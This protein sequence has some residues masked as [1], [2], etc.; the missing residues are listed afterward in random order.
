MAPARA[1]ATDF[2]CGCGRVMASSRH[3]FIAMGTER[4]SPGRPPDGMGG[5]GPEDPGCGSGHGPARG[6]L[7]ALALSSLVWLGIGVAA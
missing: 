2:P 6:I 4:G 3:G 7:V 1:P 5:S